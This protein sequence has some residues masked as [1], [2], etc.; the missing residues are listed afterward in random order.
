LPTALHILAKT[1]PWAFLILSYLVWQGLESLRART[2]PFWRVLLVP[3]VFIA[4]GVSRIIV[5]GSPHL[6]ALL[7]WTI[8]FVVWAPVAFATGPRLLAVDRSNGLVTRP[9][10]LVP[11]IRNVGV[12]TLQYAVAIMAGGKMAGSAS[13]N[14]VAHGVAGCTAGYFAGWVIVA[15]RH[16]LRAPARPRPAS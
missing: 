8:G 13:A 5:S 3:A 11:L 12:F 14:L 2:Q 1:P 7:P 4:F 6:G 15:I 10:S 9:G 16:Y